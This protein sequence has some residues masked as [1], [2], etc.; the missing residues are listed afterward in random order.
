MDPDGNEISTDDE[1]MIERART[2]TRRNNPQ[3][4][5]NLFRPV[6]RA[7]TDNTATPRDVANAS[8]AQMPAQ[9]EHMDATEP[10][11]AK[12]EVCGFSESGADPD[13]SVWT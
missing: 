6:V 7:S 2:T 12:T 5:F 11:D 9:S 13:D 8:E 4:F 3:P 1:E 10:S